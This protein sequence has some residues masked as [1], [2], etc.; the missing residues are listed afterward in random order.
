MHEMSLA[1]GILQVLESEAQRQQFTK[2]KTIW[3]EIGALANVE[4]PALEF[5]LE[6]VLRHSLAEQAKL[7]IMALPALAWCL[8]CGKTVEIKQ[9]YEACPNCG[10]YQLQV[11]SGDEMRIKE[12]EVD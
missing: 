1:E 12:L 6:V 8:P 5:A 10:S 11:S 4:I 3:L 7:H 2:V 9:R